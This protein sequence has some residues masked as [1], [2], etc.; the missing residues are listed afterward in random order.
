MLAITISF[1]SGGEIR[2][3][4]TAKMSTTRTLMERILESDKPVLEL[5]STNS[6]PLF[7]DECCEEETRGVSFIIKSTIQA[8]TLIEYEKDEE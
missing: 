8:I 6:L 2:V 5:S 3:Y 7:D 4:S 1:I